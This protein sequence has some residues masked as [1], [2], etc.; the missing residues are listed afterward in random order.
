MITLSFRGLD[1]LF[2][3]VIWKR[4]ESREKEA[5]GEISQNHKLNPI[6]GKN[7]TRTKHPKQ[8]NLHISRNSPI[9]DLEST[10]LPLQAE[11]RS[12]TLRCISKPR[13]NYFTNP[14]NFGSP[15]REDGSASSP[16]LTRIIQPQTRWSLR[17]ENDGS[18][19]ETLAMIV[20]EFR[21]EPRPLDFLGVACNQPKFPSPVNQYPTVSA[22]PSALP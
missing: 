3:S 13:R 18:A 1:S 20:R 11:F 4:E 7:S 9:H 8:Q 12:S 2:K 19:L 14:K 15:V 6:T 16:T 17:S 21:I 22:L 10:P 5:I